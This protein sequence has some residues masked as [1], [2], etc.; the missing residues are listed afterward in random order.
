MAFGRVFIQELKET[1][2]SRAQRGEALTGI[3]FAM[4]WFIGLAA[5]TA[6]PILFSVVLAFH[7]WDPYDPINE[8]VFVGF[9]NFRRAFFDDPLVWIS[10]YNTFYYAVFVVPLGLAMSLALAM[11]LNQKVRGI[12]IYRTLF[13]IPTIV[14]GVA[15]AVLWFY[16]FN[17]RFGALNTGIRAINKLIDATYIFAWIEL[18]EPYW[19]SEPAYA[20]PAL[21][22]MALWGAG[23]GTMLVFLA[24]LQGVPRHLYEVAQLDGAGRFRQFWNVTLPMI[25]PTIFFNFIMGMIVAMKVFLQA[26]VMGGINAKGGVDNSLMFY[27]LYIYKKAFLHFEMGYASA[28]A[29][30]LF[31]IIMTF[32]LIVIK[33]SPLWVYYEGERKR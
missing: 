12:Y 18:P 28:L 14:G 31:V 10:M 22:I 24:G 7:K 23:G 15:T 2:Q 32:S 25:T 33:S 29:W 6:F 17:G 5:F 11:L 8:R 27:A 30:I 3:L 4:P 16:I 20:K 21:I 26:Y 19:L 1:V 9:A 13:Y